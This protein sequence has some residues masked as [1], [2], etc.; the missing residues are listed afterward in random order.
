M[1]LLHKMPNWD[2]FSGIIFPP[3]AFPET[4]VPSI[5]KTID[6]AIKHFSSD[7]A[8]SISA[9][10]R[11]W[12]VTY[13]PNINETAEQYVK[14]MMTNNKSEVYRLPMRLLIFSSSSRLDKNLWSTSANMMTGNQQQQRNPFFP[15]TNSAATQSR[16][17]LMEDSSASVAAATANITAVA[18]ASGFASL[19]DEI[20]VHAASMNSVESSFNLHPPEPRRY[21]FSNAPAVQLALT[22]FKEKTMNTFYLENNDGFLG[23]KSKELLR[24]FFS[25]VQ[26]DGIR[27][28]VPVSCKNFTFRFTLTRY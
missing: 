2:V 16:N 27:K 22:L 28:T 15:N 18:V 19:W 7:Q 6:V 17:N 21:Y 14:R 4:V 24:R 20:H 26:I 8:K 13:S 5:K 23:S 3:S 12:G 10:W 1:F 11:H 9:E 25:N